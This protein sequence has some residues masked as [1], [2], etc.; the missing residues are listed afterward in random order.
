M[1][2]QELQA[3]LIAL[4]PDEKSN[5]IQFLSHSLET[6]WLGINKTPSLMGGE[7]CI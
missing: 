5:L 2:I 3:Q 1:T 7:A 6:P 4:T